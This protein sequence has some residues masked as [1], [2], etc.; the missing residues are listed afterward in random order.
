[1]MPASLPRGESG[2][3]T[4]SA[5]LVVTGFSGL[6]SVPAAP[7]QLATTPRTISGG[8]PISG[9][10]NLTV[11]LYRAAVASAEILRFAG[12]DCAVRRDTT[13][14]RSGLRGG[15]YWESVASQHPL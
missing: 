1:M 13:V 14:C 12:R 11:S 3:D 10:E 15:W 4:F 9:A 8:R 2:C 5:G 6:A 7:R